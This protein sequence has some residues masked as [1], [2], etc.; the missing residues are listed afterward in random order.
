MEPATVLMPIVKCLESHAWIKDYCC[1]VYFE[2]PVTAHKPYITL[3]IEEIASHTHPRICR[4]PYAKMKI[5]FMVRCWSHYHGIRELMDMIN[6]T[7]EA[8]L[9]GT[10]RSQVTKP[11]PL[12]IRLKRVQIEKITDSPRRAGNLFFEILAPYTSTEEVKDESA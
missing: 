8:L 6:A 4:S 11:D 3:E 10:L 9:R 5:G 1:G 12:R 7:K 2:P